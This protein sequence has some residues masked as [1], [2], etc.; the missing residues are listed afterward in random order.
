M[1]FYAQPDEPWTP[2]DF[3][4]LEAYQIMEDEQCPKCGQPIWLCRSTDNRIEWKLDSSI[5][6]ASRK[7]EE[8]QWY[9]HNPKKKPDK[10]ER[11]DWGKSYFPVPFVPDNVGGELPTRDEFYASLVE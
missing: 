2:F 5:C 9:R 1:L 4:I 8:S 6:Y 7:Q 3:K 10:S 11:A